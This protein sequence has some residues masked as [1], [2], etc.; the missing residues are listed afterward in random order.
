MNT[1][2]TMTDFDEILDSCLA[3]MRSGEALERC[4]DDYPEWAGE[5][6]PLLQAA[7]VIHTTSRPA[8]R[9]QA[10]S[11]GQ[12]AMLAALANRDTEGIG[13]T[14]V[15]FGA[16]RRYAERLMSV[17]KTEETSNMKPALRSI[18]TTIFVVFISG[19]FALAI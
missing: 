15:S 14:A 13:R 7:A 1:F 6:R 16:L 2:K 17:L 5:L 12:A 4:L 9:T 8:A 11:K 3:R 18:F 19:F 10:V